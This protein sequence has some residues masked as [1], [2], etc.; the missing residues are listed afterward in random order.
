MHICTVGTD[1]RLVQTCFVR[2]ANEED[3][4]SVKTTELNFVDDGV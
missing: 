4:F 1:Q 2:E 3:G